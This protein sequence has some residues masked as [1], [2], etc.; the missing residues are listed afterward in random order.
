[1]VEKQKE[2][3]K[4]ANTLDGGIAKAF[5]RLAMY[6]EVR[7]KFRALTDK[8]GCGLTPNIPRILEENVY[9]FTELRKSILEQEKSHLG[10]NILIPLPSVLLY[11]RGCEDI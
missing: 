8:L 4:D 7:M 9:I 1:M 10:K 3:V 6:L 2:I 5:W 11:E